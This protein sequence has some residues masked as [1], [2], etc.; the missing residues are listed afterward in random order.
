MINVT[1]MCACGCNKPVSPE[2]VSS[3]PE[4]CKCH[5]CVNREHIPVL[6]NNKLSQDNE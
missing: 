4:F 6:S 2:L 3:I 1:C 5:D